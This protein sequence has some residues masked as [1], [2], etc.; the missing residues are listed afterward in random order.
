MNRLLWVALL[1]L[2]VPSAA[3]QAPLF[4][5][6]GEETG[7][8]RLGPPD[9]SPGRRPEW[10]GVAGRRG[11]FFDED[12]AAVA[13]F[14][15]E[16]LPRIEGA[17]TLTARVRIDRLPREKAGIVGRWRLA[18]GGRSFE[19]GV[20]PG[21]HLFFTASAS[22]S[23]PRE[24]REIRSPEPVPVGELLELGFAFAPA[25]SMQLLVNG[26]VVRV[27]GLGVPGRL[28]AAEL[29]IHL[30]CRAGGKHHAF[31]GAITGLRIVEGA[32][33]MTSPLPGPPWKLDEVREEARRWY[34][35]L[36]DAA[37]PY[38]AYS[39]RPGQAP[40]LYASADLAWIRWMTSDLELT[41]GERAQW[42]DFIASC[43]RDD[44]GFRH[45]T[46]HCPTH[47][48]CHAT[49]AVKMLGGSHRRAPLLLEPY[50]DVERLPD[51]LDGLR[52]DRPW[53]ASHDIWGAGLPIACAPETPAGWRNAFFDWCDREVDSATGYWRR[54][55]PVD[56][57]LEGLG[58]AFHIWPI[59]AALNR[60]LPHP[61]RIIDTT[62]SMQQ[63]DGSFDGH[64]NYGHMDAL[65]VLAHLLIR[66]EHR[67]DEV[68]AA[69]ERATAGLMEL[70]R[71]EC[72]RFFSD[73]HGTLS[74]IASLAI[75][76]EVLPELFE[77]SHLWR[78]P[79]A[80]REL[81]AI[82]F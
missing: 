9:G 48:F 7:A 78:D 8:L 76:Y 58:G 60:P 63:A 25:K 49:G 28:F 20:L 19:L 69:L 68:R 50:R 33:P 31:H 21:G 56:R 43:Q 62:L 15:P 2:F 35:T 57:P 12:Q 3:A 64:F 82:S 73:A 66:V 29:P 37:R 17:V 51:W 80:R 71:Y 32:Q 39:L 77:A 45:G 72:D 11:L 36:R 4:S 24:A 13:T 6:Q 65:W 59:Y 52:W 67:R 61:E 55:V 75:C 53:G 26:E 44:G 18:A 81:F 1:I 23:W 40:D 70:E 42:L 16:V 47:A 46:G 27:T 5:W 41:D 38:G 10:I 34:A 22:G 54:G 30:G 14:A 74:R 79:W